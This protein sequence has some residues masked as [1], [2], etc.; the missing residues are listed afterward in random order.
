MKAAVLSKS[1]WTN[2]RILITGG[3]T[4]EPI[5]QV[6]SITN[7]STGRLGQTIVTQ[8][9]AKTDWQVDYITTPTALQAQKNPRLETFW[10]SDTADLLK[11]L[12][13]LM[14]KNHYDAVIH[15]MAVSDFTGE[16]AF[17]QTALIEKMLTEKPEL[18][19]AG[20]EQFFDSLSQTPSTE[21]KISSDTQRLILTLQKTPKVIA[22]IKRIQP[23]TILIGFKLLVAV[24]P[25]ELLAVAAA[26]LKKNHADFILANDLTEISGDQHHGY[27]LA[28]D[29]SVT[30]AFTKPEIAD[31]LMTKILETRQ[32]K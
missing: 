17:S 13:D 22:E 2:M 16:A 4:T 27:L 20:L 5:D 12:T 28:K 7:Q 18:T 14:T 26:S 25:A 11:M 8:I 23:E 21:T 6:R 9:L 24:P 32:A 15:S 19:T 30:E 1:R 10:I 29:G 31:L 3:G